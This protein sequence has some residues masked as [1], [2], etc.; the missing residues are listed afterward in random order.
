MRRKKEKIIEHERRWEGK[1]NERYSL[2]GNDLIKGIDGIGYKKI[3]SSE[4]NDESENKQKW[5]NWTLE[6][7]YLEAFWEKFN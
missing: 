6:K 7:G 5:V 2:K 4:T 3:L 1:E